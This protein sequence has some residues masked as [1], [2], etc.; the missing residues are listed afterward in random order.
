M[1]LRQI[2][3]PAVDTPEA[4]AE[5]LARRGLEAW[6]DVT[7]ALPGRVADA[8][9]EAAAVMEPNSNDVHL[10]GAVIKTPDDLDQ[11]LAT[12][13]ERLAAGLADGPVIPKI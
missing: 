13:R 4:V 7:K 6:E 10:P 5:A 12:V 3:R 2:E 11:W 8:L 1:G 9:A